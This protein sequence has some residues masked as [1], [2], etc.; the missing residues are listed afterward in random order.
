M[1]GSDFGAKT[2][3]AVNPCNVFVQYPCHTPNFLILYFSPTPN[4][5][6][7]HS[8]TSSKIVRKA[9]KV[10]GIACSVAKVM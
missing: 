7:P 6:E 5:Q 8:E 1:K 2:T 4:T 10:A 9:I 3:F